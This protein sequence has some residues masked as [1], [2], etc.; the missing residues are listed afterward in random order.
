MNSTIS[1]EDFTSQHR[2]I[3]RAAAWAVFLI[4]VVYTVI[5]ALGFLSLKLPQDPI[6]EPFCSLME[7]LIFSYYP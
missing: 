5:T 4:G 3:G 6:G 2:I 7:L 1:H